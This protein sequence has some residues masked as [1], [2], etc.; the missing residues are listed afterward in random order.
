MLF[1][2][3][4]SCCG[5]WTFSGFLWTISSPPQ[6]LFMVIYGN[7]QQPLPLFYLLHLLL[8]GALLSLSS[9]QLPPIIFIMLRVVGLF[10][11]VTL[12][13]ASSSRRFGVIWIKVQTKLLG[14]GPAAAAAAA[15]F[16]PGA[17]VHVGAAGGRQQG[18]SPHSSGRRQQPVS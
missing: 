1:Q 15:E 10:F 5:S 9:S 3:K 8:T 11:A 6:R 16:I 14:G 2:D 17:L 12:A 18:N 7:H 13:M 4:G